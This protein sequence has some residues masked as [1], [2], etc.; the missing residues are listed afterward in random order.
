MKINLQIFCCWCNGNNFVKSK[1]SGKNCSFPADADVV[2]NGEEEELSSSG[3]LSLFSLWENNLFSCSS[4]SAI[5]LPLCSRQI[6]V[7]SY[8]DTEWE[9][10]STSLRTKYLLRVM[11]TSGVSTRLNG[12]VSK[13]RSTFPQVGQIWAYVAIIRCSWGWSTCFPSP[14]T[15]SVYLQSSLVMAK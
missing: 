6:S 1:K 15:F 14:E 10:E 12:S 8:D 11:S 9:T 5:V 4:P 13:Q 7:Y 3:S 2:L